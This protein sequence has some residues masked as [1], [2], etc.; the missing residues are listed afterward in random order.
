LAGRPADDNEGNVVWEYAVFVVLRGGS[1]HLKIF[2]RRDD[3]FSQP[4]GAK[5]PFLV[6]VF[7]INFALAIFF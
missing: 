2:K 3:E 5:F 1:P 4:P 7:L 6:G